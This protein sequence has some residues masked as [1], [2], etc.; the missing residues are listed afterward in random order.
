MADVV[1][2]GAGHNG[3]VAALELASQGYDTVV[4]EQSDRVGGAVGSGEV[5]VAGFVH[6]LYATNLNLF[7]A[8][9][10]YRR[11]AADLERHG[12]RFAVTGKPFSS[13][14][15]S[16]IGQPSPSRLSGAS[17][18]SQSEKRSMTG[19][20]SVPPSQNALPSSAHTQ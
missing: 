11:R 14:A 19:E 17:S 16:A 9:P 3:L 18:W 1:V 6:D 7:L 13:A 12:L 4:V 8:S 15:Q 2:V 10:V 20:P 5:T